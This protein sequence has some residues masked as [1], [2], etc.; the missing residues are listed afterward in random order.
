MHKIKW[1][2]VNLIQKV[3]TSLGTAILFGSSLT[4]DAIPNDI[5]ILLLINVKHFIAIRGELKDISGKFLL[6]F[7]IDLHLTIIT[8]KEEKDCKEFMARVSRKPYLFLI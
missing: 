2:K 1:I 4:P 7:N 6:E 3:D 5:D 8:D